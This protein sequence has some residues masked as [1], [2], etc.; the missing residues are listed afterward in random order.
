MN[1][2]AVSALA[3]LASVALVVACAKVQP[4]SQSPFIDTLPPGK[5]YRW[6]GR[7][8]STCYAWYTPNGHPAMDCT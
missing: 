1:Y 3:L 5:V 6:T 4:A 7:G 2:F 8:G